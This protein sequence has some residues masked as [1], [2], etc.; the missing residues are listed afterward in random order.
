MYHNVSDLI[1]AE[2]AVVEEAEAV[3]EEE[4]ESVAEED[5]TAGDAAKLVGTAALV[6]AVDEAL[7]P[8]EPVV[9]PA[10]EPFLEPEA[11]AFAIEVPSPVEEAGAPAR[12]RRAIKIETIEG[13]GPV[14][15]T[16]LCDVGVFTTDELLAAGASRKGREELVEKTGISSKLILR[17][18]NMAD[19]MRVPGIGEEYS[20]LLEAAGVDTVKELRNRNPNNL[21][22]AMIVANNQKKLVRRVPHLTEV[23]SWVQ[24]AKELDVRMTY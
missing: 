19:L 8:D 7:N 22:N 20:E 23:Q 11:V 1:R 4:E 2:Q 18:V 5:L 10:V 9:E 24:A 12:H 15:T 16:K 6:T 21:Y 3:I 17:W 13:I 14:Y